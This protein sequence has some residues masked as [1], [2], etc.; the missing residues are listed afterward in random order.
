MLIFLCLFCVV[1]RVADPSLP[2]LFVQLCVLTFVYFH[3]I[4]VYTFPFV[5]IFVVV[6]FP[7]CVGCHESG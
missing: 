6:D 1:I 4:F 5:T 3:I 2:F 7:S